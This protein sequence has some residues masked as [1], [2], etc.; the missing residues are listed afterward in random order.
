M[1][2]IPRST[3]EETETQKGEH[4]KS[5]DHNTH[6]EIQVASCIELFL[7]AF[8]FNVPLCISLVDF[9][10]TVQS[11]MREFLLNLNYIKS[12]VIKDP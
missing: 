8:C 6:T 12:Q 10:Q 5:W 11:L 2:M 3:G 9:R 1:E 4:A 7:L